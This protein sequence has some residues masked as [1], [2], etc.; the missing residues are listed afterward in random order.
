MPNQSNLR[1]GFPVEADGS[2]QPDRCVE[3]EQSSGKAREGEIHSFEFVTLAAMLMA[4]AAL[5][6]D[7]MLVALPDIARTFAVVEENDRQLV[8]TNYPGQSG[9]A[10]KVLSKD[11]RR[12]VYYVRPSICTFVEE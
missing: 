3:M 9:E 4:M 5:G 2:H 1:P 10:Y 6:M 12:A 8:V 11:L 7:T